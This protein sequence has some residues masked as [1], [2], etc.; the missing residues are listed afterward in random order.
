MRNTNLIAGQ[1]KYLRRQWEAIKEATDE[2]EGS[3]WLGRRRLKGAGNRAKKRLERQKR[4]AEQ[5]EFLDELHNPPED[6]RLKV[7]F[8]YQLGER[9]AKQKSFKLAGQEFLPTG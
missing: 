8:F 7:F 5:Q 4:E 6:V 2:L 1:P 3:H 9:F